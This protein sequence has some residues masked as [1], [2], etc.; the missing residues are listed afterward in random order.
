MIV[1]PSSKCT[2]SA[3]ARP[4]QLLKT[5]TH[6]TPG[7]GGYV[8]CRGVPFGPGTSGSPG[9]DKDGDGSD[10]KGCAETRSRRRLATRPRPCAGPGGF[11][12]SG[13]CSPLPL[14]LLPLRLSR[15]KLPGAA[16]PGPEGVGE[17]WR[18]A[19]PPG[20]VTVNLCHLRGSPLPFW[21]ALSAH[22]QHPLCG[23]PSEEEN[24]L[25][26]GP[27]SLSP[28]NLGPWASCWAAQ[29]RSSPAPGL[30]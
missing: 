5:V 14:L 10:G 9:K 27:E 19:S 16:G 4:A 26:P 18:T 24:A 8:G 29:R 7:Q 25:G 28:R 13:L 12:Q 1:A 21:G 22:T 2:D 20:T 11:V 15:A 23:G 17:C 30:L 3:S 6:P